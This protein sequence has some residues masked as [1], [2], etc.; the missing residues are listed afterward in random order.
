MQ[1]C[2]PFEFYEEDEEGKEEEEKG[3]RAE[4][5]EQGLEFVCV[6]ASQNEK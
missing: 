4:E 3:K 6:D 1:R 5:A 2:V